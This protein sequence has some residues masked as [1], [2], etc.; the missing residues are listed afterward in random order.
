MILLLCSDLDFSIYISYFPI[1]NRFYFF[2]SSVMSGE[3]TSPEVSQHVRFSV[4]TIVPFY[5]IPHL[6]MPTYTYLHLPILT[7]FSLFLGFH[8][9]I[10]QSICIYVY[11][12]LE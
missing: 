2:N 3:E 11:T 5:P 1:T 9:A 12:I 6:P 7:Y 8:H 4:G 10:L